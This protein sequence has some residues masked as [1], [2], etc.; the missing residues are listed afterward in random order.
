VLALEEH[1]PSVCARISTEID[2]AIAEDGVETIVLGCAGMA[3]LAAELMETLVR[4]G[5]RASRLGAWRPSPSK[6]LRRFAGRFRVRVAKIEIG[7]GHPL[8]DIARH[9]DDAARGI[10]A[11]QRHRFKAA[12]LKGETEIHGLDGVA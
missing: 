7:V 11:A 3:N 2:A 8:I 12:R 4:L 1:T 10:D 9:R 6:T 5:H